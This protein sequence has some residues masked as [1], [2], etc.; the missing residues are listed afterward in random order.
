MIKNIK[1]LHKFGSFKEFNKSNDVEDFSKYNVLFAYNGTGKTTLSR[2]FNFL[3]NTKEITQE[4]IKDGYE[5]NFEIETSEGVSIKSFAEYTNKIKVF[6][7]DFINAELDFDKTELNSISVEFGKDRKII[8]EQIEKL[9]TKKENLYVYDCR[10]KKATDKLKISDFSVDKEKEL[11]DLYSSIALKIRTELCIANASSYRAG[12]FEDDSNNLKLIENI[13]EE[14]KTNTVKLYKQPIKTEITYI[15]ECNNILSEETYNEI[16]DLLKTPVSRNE[17]FKDEILNWIETGMSF[18]IK[19]N[20]NKCYFCDNKITDWE[21]RLKEL[22]LL[23]KKDDSFGTFE[24]NV[25]KF[26]NYINEISQNL[27]S[28]SFIKNGNRNL[29]KEDFLDEF[30][31]NA[32]ELIGRVGRYRLDYANN[33]LKELKQTIKEKIENPKKELYFLKMAEQVTGNQR[34]FLTD[35]GNPRNLLREIGALKDVI[36]KHNEKLKEQKNVK[37][38]YKKIVVKYY[39]QENKEKIEDLKLKISKANKCE[40]VIRIFLDKINANISGLE[41]Q[42]DRQDEIIELIE[43]YIKII[44][45]SQKFKFD[46]DPISKTYS[47]KRNDN[48]PAKHL[49]EG[50]KTVISFAYFLAT[51]ESK[52][53]DLK[54][55]IVVID[56]PV[57]SLDQNYLFNLINLLCRKFKAPKKFKQLFILTHNFYF[58]KKI[59]SILQHIEHSTN[60]NIPD[61]NNKE[62]LLQIFELKKDDVSSR[63]DKG[64]KFLSKYQSEYLS[65]IEYLKSEL[66]KPEEIISIE[67]GVAIRKIFE[68][69]LAYQQPQE[70]TIFARFTK[71]FKNEEME[72]LS[73]LEGIAN[74]SCHTDEISDLDSLE[75]YKLAVGKAE[76]NQLFEFIY[77]TDEKHFNSLGLNKLDMPF[78]NK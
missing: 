40:P 69:F 9:I 67:K 60:S 28:V 51:L 17:K 29:L 62:K 38:E 11:K 75:E 26:E 1:K 4:Y 13:T 71:T 35:Y 2:F 48:I 24:T 21:V 78:L 34:R 14:E 16:S 15:D 55:N 25:E 37:E 59:K 46:Y 77:I 66:R 5:E 3:G 42:L 73:Y 50:E 10:A 47:I 31:V 61:D 49:S 43:K 30:Q 33:Y 32:E 22:E 65:Q 18:D 76:I 72:T 8:K 53:F 20:Q 63:I 45:T 64:S 54:E 74:A 23:V 27:F 7:V 70:T 56:D 44:F 57:S 12:H 58:F 39:I 6:N 36:D 19:E 52:D 41:A 68:I